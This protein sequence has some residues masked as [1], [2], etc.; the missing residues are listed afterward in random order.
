MSY[1]TWLSLG[2]GAIV[3]E[4]MIPTLF[5][6]FIGIGFFAAG[7]VAYFFP[8]MIF[9]Q[10]FT[11]AVTTVIIA[12]L[13]RR[14][15]DNHAALSEVGTHN[16]FV[17]V[18]G[19]ALTPLSAYDEGEVLFAQSVMSARQWNALSLNDPIDEGTSIEIVSVL[20]NTLI[21]KPHL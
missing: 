2:V 15:E 4:M 11:A 8:E 9:V 20:G 3:I 16:E 12:I 17:G 6:L 13:F 5:S 7:A 1:Y 18:V 19:K 21:V 10:L 14:R